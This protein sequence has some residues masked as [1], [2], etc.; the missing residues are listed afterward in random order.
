MLSDHFSISSES[1][2]LQIVVGF[3]MKAQI[4]GVVYSASY[5]AN[6][7]GMW[8]VFRCLLK[9]QNPVNFFYF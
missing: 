1:G 4:I 6:M 2:I 7:N 8:L 9:M 3:V 5:I